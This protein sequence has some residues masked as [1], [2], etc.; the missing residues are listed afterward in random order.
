MESEL[1]S[2]LP[3]LYSRLSQCCADVAAAI[4]RRTKE[5]DDLE[6]YK[7]DVERCFQELAALAQA[8][9]DR[10]KAGHDEMM[11]LQARCNEVSELLLEKLKAGEPPDPA[12]YWKGE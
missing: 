11:A 6:A 5:L 8:N 10:H 3:A 9:Y 2:N 12:D 4:E 1:V 7:A